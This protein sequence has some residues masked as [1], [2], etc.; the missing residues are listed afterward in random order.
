M[1]TTAFC[2]PDQAE[3]ICSDLL[4][5]LYIILIAEEIQLFIIDPIL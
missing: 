4:Y 3:Q 1:E 5:V 2:L